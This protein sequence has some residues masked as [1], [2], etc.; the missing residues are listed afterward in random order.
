MIDF[1]KL[2]KILDTYSERDLCFTT[3]NN[4]IIENITCND[5]NCT[6]CNNLKN[7]ICIKDIPF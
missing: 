3:I 6:M 4:T 7:G 5:S 2:K 1:L